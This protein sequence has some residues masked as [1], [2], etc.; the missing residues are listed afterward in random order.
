MERAPGGQGEIY[1][2]GHEAVGDALKGAVVAIGNFDGLHRGHL[3][4]FERAKRRA[5]ERGAKAAVLTFEPHPVRVV[6]P[7]FAPPLILTLDEKLAGI[8]AAGISAVM[9]QPFDHAFAKTPPRAFV[10]DI[11]VRSLQVSGVVVGTDFSFGHK[12]AGTVADLERWLAGHDVTVDVV[13]PVTEGGMVCS[14]TKV[15]ELVREGRVDAASVI[16]GRTYSLTG[17]VEDGDKRGKRMKVPTANLRTTREL[18]PRIGVYATVAKLD[19]GRLLESV[20]NVG[21]RPT[22][23]GEGVRVE[24]HLL[25]YDGHLYGRPLELFFH[26]RLRDERKFAS[27]DELRQQIAKDVEAARA[28]LARHGPRAAP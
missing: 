15:R 17:I 14:S 1:G 12:G 7:R 8:L 18:L 6:A 25:D 19:D 27:A 28:A 16:L 22:F 20:T 2:A 10:E 11:L 21:L 23:D 13:P 26:E 3:A 9:V 5:E 4:L 24:A